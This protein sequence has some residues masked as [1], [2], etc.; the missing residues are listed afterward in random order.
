MTS[1]VDAAVGLDG[2][3][4]HRL[5]VLLRVRASVD[6][7]DLG[8]V[9]LELGAELLECLCAPGREGQACAVGGERLGGGAAEGAGR[10]GDQRAAAGDVEEARDLVGLRGRGAHR[11]VPSGYGMTTSIDAGT[12]VWFVTD[13]A[14]F[15]AR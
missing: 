7:L 1:E 11:S 10:A 13:R 6:E 15:G 5:G 4:R 12:F 9:V 3:L 2:G 14:S 8:A